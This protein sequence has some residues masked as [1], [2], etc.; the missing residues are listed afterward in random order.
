MPSLFVSPSWLN[1]PESVISA[2]VSRSGNLPLDVYLIE[3]PEQDYNPRLEYG[4]QAIRPYAAR[5]R[6]L[7]IF[8]RWRNQENPSI[9]FFSAP[10]S[11][12]V[13]QTLIIHSNDDFLLP[14]NLS[15]LPLLHTLHVPYQP[16]RAEGSYGTIKK[17]GCRVLDSADSTSLIDLVRCQTTSFH[18]TIFADR[19]ENVP[20]A[21]S[22]SEYSTTCWAWLT[23]LR[24]DGFSGLDHD[25]VGT[26]FSQLYAPR[27]RSL[28]L[29]D[30]DEDNLRVLIDS[31]VRGTHR[32]GVRIYSL[33]PLVQPLATMQSIET[34]LLEPPSAYINFSFLPLVKSQSQRAR[35]FP[36]ILELAIWDVAGALEDGAG[37][38]IDLPSIEE[39]LSSRRNTMKRLILP[40]ALRPKSHDL[41]HEDIL[42]GEDKPRKQYTPLTSR[43]H[44]RLIAA[45]NL[46]EIRYE[47]EVDNHG[48]DLAP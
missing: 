35:A 44:A 19:S 47:Y 27:L 29:V 7:R 28:E 13:L 36:K 15:K 26:L 39:Y 45:G 8:T 33:D 41:S 20:S 14:L 25:N 32:R 10:P 16:L 17:L 43:E 31:L 34:V 1:W 40:N 12:P 38:W 18:L 30:M 3:Q 37:W 21:F 23:S 22:T 6:S 46:D 9:A 24:V 2:W 42:D 5:L 11:F 48:V 4:L